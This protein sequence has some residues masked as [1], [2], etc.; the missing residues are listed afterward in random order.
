VYQV[1]FVVLALGRYS[2]IPKFLLGKGPEVFHGEVIHFKDYAA[3]DYEVATK[4]IKGK[5]I[6]VVGAKRSALD[7]AMECC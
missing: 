5:R 7:I 6:V 4:Y 3:M 2:G 1:D